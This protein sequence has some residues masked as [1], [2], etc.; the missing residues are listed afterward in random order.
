MAIKDSKYLR[1]F[2]WKYIVVDEGHRLKNMD[3][4]LI[5][6]LKTFSSANRL[7]LTGTPLHNNLSELWSLLNF[8]LPDIFDDLDSFQQWCDLLCF[9]ITLL[10]DHAGVSELTA[11]ISQVRSRL[12]HPQAFEPKRPRREAHLGRGLAQHRHQAP[13]DPQAV[14]PPAAQG[15]R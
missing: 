15:R 10:L 9:S 4:L 13:L 5:R 1:G 3:C 12:G 8:I 14:P 6:E 2:L 11:A 7:I